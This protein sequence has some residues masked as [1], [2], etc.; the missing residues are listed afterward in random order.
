MTP[1]FK[2]KYFSTFLKGMAM[3]AA[4]VV[5]GVSG[6]T[7]AFVSGIYQEL[8]DSISKLHVKAFSVLKNQGL[9]SFWSYINGSFLASLF[10]GIVCSVISLAKGISW[11]LEE[12]P[13]LLWS[14]FF[15]LVLASVVYLAKELKKVDWWQYI[16]AVIGITLALYISSL[17]VSE[18][19]Q[20][21]W[22]LFLSGAV[23]ICAM[24]LPGISG[25]FILVLMG[26]YETILQAV[27][28]RD[29]TII[30]IVGAGAITGLSIF[31]RV[32]KWTFKHFK[33][34]TLL[35]LIG[36]VMGS[37]STIWPWKE[38]LNSVQIGDKE[39]VLAT[40][41]VLPGNFSSEPQ[42]LLA[43]TFGLVGFLLIFVLERAATYK[44]KQS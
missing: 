44:P 41:N 6:G 11:L 1:S 21:L 33:N 24:I 16:W 39:I 13:I 43:V 2:R 25:A 42:L 31:S 7:I 30:C 23:A 9:S 17:G 3:G 26:S 40:K 35:L 4:D 34:Q 32:L 10:A 22:Y 5:P 27:H 12:Q 18:N 36:F 19:S 28:Q 38:V 29:L 37:L 8:L 14:F 15:G 20:S